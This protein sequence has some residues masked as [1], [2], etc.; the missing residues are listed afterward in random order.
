MRK[1]LLRARISDLVE[2][3]SD[4]YQSTLTPPSDS[5]ISGIKVLVFSEDCGVCKEVLTKD[6]LSSLEKAGVRLVNVEEAL[7]FGADFTD[8]NLISRDLVVRTPTVV[9]EEAVEVTN[10]RSRIE[11][12]LLGYITPP[13]ARSGRASS[14][15]SGSKASS[16]SGS[17]T[18]KKAKKEEFIENKGLK[19]EIVKELNK[20][21]SEVCVE[22]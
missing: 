3:V 16:R 8:S 21:D 1:D 20:C 4:T 7:E 22:Y 10:N 18:R 11:Y 6:L 13:R 17:R 9:T 15:G 19:R 12:L 14:T 2:V 5:G